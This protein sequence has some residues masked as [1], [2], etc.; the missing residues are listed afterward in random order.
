[1]GSKVGLPWL[2]FHVEY[3]RHANV[4]HQG[5]VPGFKGKPEA[6]RELTSQSPGESWHP[7]PPSLPCPASLWMFPLRHCDLVPSLMTHW[8]LIQWLP[9]C[10]KLYLALK[11]IPKRAYY[12]CNRGEKALGLN[13]NLESL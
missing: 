5:D 6:E 11:Y 8:K 12:S 1:M 13:P 2:E 9:T 4:Q 3:S 7:P 10:I